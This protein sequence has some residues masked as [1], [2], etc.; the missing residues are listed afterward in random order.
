M[1]DSR[2][3]ANMATVSGGIAVVVG[4]F[5][6]LEGAALILPGSGLLALGGYLAGDERRVI[7]QRVWNF[8]LVAIG[9]AALFGLSALGGVGGT[10][11][12]SAWWALLILPYVVGWSLMLWGPGSPR[13]V[14]F[15][16]IV[17]GIW[18]L[19]ILAMLMR[20]SGHPSSLAPAIGIGII[21][22]ATVV[23]CAVRLRMNAPRPA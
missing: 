13:W 12:L 4:S 7:T 17:I 15:A 5:D 18:Y 14:S 1:R 22:M 2:R 21:G 19:A 11:A 10:S 20:G 3:W 8:I 6:P 9:V 23:A 16:G